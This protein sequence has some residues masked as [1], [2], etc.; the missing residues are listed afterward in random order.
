MPERGGGAGMKGCCGGAALGAVG[1]LVLAVIVSLPSS[2]PV[3]PTP[4][5]SPSTN[6]PVQ[7]ARWDFISFSTGW[8][9]VLNRPGISQGL[10]STADGGRNW[11]QVSAPA[12]DPLTLFGFQPLDNRHLLAPTDSPSAL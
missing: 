1:A 2:P 6:A 10:Y 8:V 4:V 5:A 3:Q 12:S 7:I 9:E 11:K